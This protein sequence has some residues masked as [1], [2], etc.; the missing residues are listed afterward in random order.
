M[1]S[2][3][4][5]EALVRFV[6][7]DLIRVLLAGGNSCTTGSLCLLQGFIG[8]AE[9]QAQEIELRADLAKLKAEVAAQG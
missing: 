8:C 9:R 6:G 7:S 3:R 2:P 4:P 1:A 5:A